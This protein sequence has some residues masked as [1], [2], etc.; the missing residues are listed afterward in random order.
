MLDH[1]RWQRLS[2]LLDRAL[3]LDIGER[4]AWLEQLRGEDPALAAELEAFLEE[5]NTLEREGFLSHSPFSAFAQQSSLIGQTIGV[6][7]LEAPLGQGGMGTVWLARR[8]DGRFEGKVAIK[9]L[10]AA[11]VGRAGEERFQREG[12][13]LARLTHPNIAR[14]IDAGVSA[15]GQPYLVLEYVEGERIDTYCDVNR[16]GVAARLRLFL[17]VL[18]AIANAH[19]NLV[20]H[21]DIKPS[22]VMV[23]ERGTVKLLDFGIAKLLQDEG[24]LGSATELTRDAGRAL[25]PEFAAPEQLLG[26]PV[27]TATDVYALGVLL[28]SLLAGQHPAEGHTGSAAELIKAI[29]DT[30][31]P[32][33]SDA[34]TAKKTLPKKTLRENAAKRAATP[35]RLK[36]ALRGD[37]DNIVGKAL[38]KDPQERY[39]S[40]TAFADDIRRHMQHEPVSARSDSF[41]YRAAKFVRRNRVAVA[42]SALAVVALIGGLAGTITQAQRATRQAAIAERQRDEARYQAQRAEASSEVM[43][44]MLEE[45]GPGGKPLALDALIDRGV[46]L[47]ERRYGADPHLTG[48]MMVQM[49]HRYM[50][51]DRPVKARETLDRAIAIARQTDDAEVAASAQCLLAHTE[52]REAKSDDAARALAEG[53]SAIAR[54]AAPGVQTQVECLR[55]EAYLRNFEGRWNDALRPLEKARTLLERTGDTRTLLYTTTLN[56]LG[57]VYFRS[58]R[59]REGLANNQT[60]LDLFERNGRGKTVSYT[61]LIANRASIL[62]NLGEITASEAQ[63]RSARERVEGFPDLDISSYA[64]HQGRALV[65]LGRDAEAIELLRNAA[66]AGEAHSANAW[67]SRARFELAQ[68]LMHGRDFAAAEDELAR[69]EAF[70]TRDPNVNA[71]PLLHVALVRAEIALAQDQK[72][73]AQKFVDHARTYLDKPSADTPFYSIRLNRT[74]AVVALAKGDSTAAD[75][76]AAESLRIAEDVARDASASADV[77]EALLLQAQAKIARGENDSARPLLERASTSLAGGLGADHPLTQLAKDLLGKNVAASSR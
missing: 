19:A 6:Y 12:S 54:L 7:T 21:R 61:I 3:D 32:R 27:T 71:G 68:A 39:M 51:L 41:G 49:A 74:A 18:A 58:G 73:E 52:A 8:S 53:K 70:L 38:K 44:L 57:Y 5:Q 75:T 22:N 72:E 43:S 48:L 59:W 4:S 1:D 40:I 50:D 13:I 25:T 36:H 33:L 60:L 23:G 35:E 45:I 77:G 69:A 64:Y 76:F 15:T 37:L 28:Y 55:A 24:A 63:A 30:D 11:L 62:Y 10:N 46:E 20:I 29:V 66:A 56:D 26:N 67:A 31:S 2:P 42:L 14:L 65:R 34:V 17:D 16:L 9:L 47:L